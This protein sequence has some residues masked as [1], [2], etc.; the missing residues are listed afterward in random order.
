MTHRDAGQAKGLVRRLTCGLL[1]LA[2]SACSSL[3]S[4]GPSARAVTRS[5]AKPVANADIKIVDVKEE[6]AQRI[7][8]AGRA[9]LFS[10]ALG[11]GPPALT[12]IGKGDVLDIAI[13]EAPPAALFG[14]VGGEAALA[15]AGAAIGVSSRGTTFPEQMVDDAG[16]VS[17]PFAGSIPVAGLSPR[18]VEREIVARLDGKAHL[19]QAI[20]RLTR[21]A[22]ANVTVVGDV[23]SSARVPLT[24]KGERLLDALASAGG[25][26]QPVGKTTIR[27]TRGRQVATLPLETIL[28]DPAQ[29]IRLQP[30]D[31]V[32]A[33][34]QPYSFTALGAVTN[35]A[36]IPFEGTGITVAQALGRV[37][38]LQDNRADIRGVFI[39]RLEDPAALDPAIREGARTTP[40]GRI[41]VI[42]RIDM[43]DPATFFIA[44]SFPIRNNDVLY[45]SNAP[46]ADLQKFVSIVSSMVFSVINLGNAVK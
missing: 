35:N 6:A 7:I 44:Q 24:S 9:A 8:S 3:G 13:W 18:Q 1:V 28:L 10:E 16:R 36:E 41:P 27:I 22:S 34:F 40:D 14:T 31:V 32:T 42:Y 29:N 21:N 46:L 2:L 17:L 38:G 12:V 15:G 25:V 4:S 26:K 20:V 37:G 30:D 43:R 33:L 45:V 5:G 19:P 39:F 11:D 23:A